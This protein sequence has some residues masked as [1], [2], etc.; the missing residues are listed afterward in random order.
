[1]P[2][3]RK[4]QDVSKLADFRAELAYDD[5]C[6]ECLGELDEGFECHDCGYDAEP[7]IDHLKDS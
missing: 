7:D 1:M 3:V 4:G 6:P 5:I 2:L